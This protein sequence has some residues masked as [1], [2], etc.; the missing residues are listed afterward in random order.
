VIGATPV[1]ALTVIQG[2]TDVVVSGQTTVPFNPAVP[3]SGSTIVSG[4]I[5]QIVISSATTV[6]LS[7]VLDALPGSTTLISGILEVVLG[8][9]TIPVNSKLPGLSGSTTVISGTPYVVISASTT[10]PVVLGNP[11]A[12]TG[13]GSNDTTPLQVS[14]CARSSVSIK[15]EVIMLLISVAALSLM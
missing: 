10:V 9:T 15:K 1:S 13:G 14:A 6:P 11:T 7:Q 12:G 5:T 4:G 3:V 2:A 8:P